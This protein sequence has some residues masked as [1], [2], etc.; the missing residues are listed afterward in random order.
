MSKGFVYVLSNPSM[1]G[2]VKIGKTTREVESRANELY[3]IG[4]PVPFVIEAQF[5]SPDC[6]Q[7]EEMVHNCLCD[8]RVNYSRE[9]F[10]VSVSDA[11]RHVTNA[12]TEQ[13]EELVSEYMPNHIIAES[14]EVLDVANVYPS[15]K[16]TD[17]KIHQITEAVY[18]LTADEIKPAVERYLK[19]YADQARIENADQDLSDAQVLQ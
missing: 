6:H 13:V 14:W 1:P 8:Q 17:L 12:L 3:S 16:E 2:L 9:F 15:V 4:V 7:L 19:K 5:S 10:N 11:K 18:E